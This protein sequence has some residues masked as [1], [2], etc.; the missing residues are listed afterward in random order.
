MIA[1]TFEERSPLADPREET[2][3]ADDVEGSNDDQEALACGGEPGL[4]EETLLWALYPLL[5]Y[6]SGVGISTRSPSPIMLL[7]L[8][9]L[10]NSVPFEVSVGFVMGAEMLTPPLCR[11]LCERVF[12]GIADRLGGGS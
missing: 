4:I 9:N 12:T 3:V 7:P 2:R 6:G 8:E 1:L 10:L 5:R 11:I